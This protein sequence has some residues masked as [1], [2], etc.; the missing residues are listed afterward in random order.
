MIL[1]SEEAKQIFLDAKKEAGLKLAVVKAM[2]YR[3][4]YAKDMSRA[5]EDLK[6]V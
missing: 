1:D 6:N 4:R 5:I 2:K 3:N